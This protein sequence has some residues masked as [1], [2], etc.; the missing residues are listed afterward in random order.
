MTLLAGAPAGAIALAALPDT[1]VADG[2]AVAS[3]AASGIQDGNGNPIEDGETFTI[4]TD[5]GTIEKY[6]FHT[7]EDYVFRAQRGLERN[8][9]ATER[10]GAMSRLS[11]RPRETQH[12]KRTT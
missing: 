1:I 12:S 6:D 10:P 4:S 8:Q 7:P 5:L 2:E 11:M 3:V 9:V